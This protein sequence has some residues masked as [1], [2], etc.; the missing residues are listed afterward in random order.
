M[1]GIRLVDL[2]DSFKID[3]HPDGYFAFYSRDR[4]FFEGLSRD[5]ARDP[6]VLL[7]YGLNGSPL[8]EVHGGPLRLVVPFLQGYK[9]VK[10]V[11]TIH[12]FRH[13][14]VG[15]KR[16]LAQS[17]TGQLNDKWRGQF[18]IVPGGK[19][20]ILRYGARSRQ[21][22]PRPRSRLRNPGARPGRFGPQRNSRRGRRH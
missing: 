17:P 6:R 8:P 13:D 5:E 7:A 22:P 20:E 1:G 19:S 2:L 18:Q 3:T 15:I 10:W 14:P 9:S 21:S 4:V 16:L 11:H 12:A